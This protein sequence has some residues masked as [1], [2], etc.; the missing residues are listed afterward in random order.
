LEHG[1]DLVIQVYA[2]DG[3]HLG[4]FAHRGAGDAELGFSNGLVVDD[5]GIYAV[6]VSGLPDFGLRSAVR[7]WAPIE[8]GAAPAAP[9]TPPKVAWVTTTG[10]SDFIP[11]SLAKAP[12][13]KI[14]AS[15]ALT[16]EFAIFSPDGTYL[17][18]WGEPGNGD[19][20]FDL[21]RANGDPFGMLAFAPD[22]S[23][24]VLD[25]G[26]HR[27]QVFDE[28]RRFVR[29]WG[30]FGKEPGQ[31]AETGG[32]V[33]DRDGNVVVVDNIRNVIET[34]KPD[35]T[36]VSTVT[37]FPPEANVATGP[38]KGANQMALG[39][40]GD[41]FLGAAE[42]GVVIEVDRTGKLVRTWGA[43]GD[44]CALSEQP[45]GM[46]W[47]AQGRMYLGQGPDRGDAPGILVF[48]SDGSCLGGFGPEGTSD[49]QVA[50]PWGIVVDDTGIYVA[51]AGGVPDMGFRSSITKFEP[52]AP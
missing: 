27:V 6:D 5:T 32:L 19:G 25:S 18:T 41:L 51:D 21:R 50:F 39:P 7:K 48:G 13:G 43:A 29:S 37:A 44:A 4:G 38:N 17:E 3:S 10:P 15:L 52:L 14:W 35:G 30:T 49:G 40:N 28:H 8:F 26:N 12:D 45:N 2:P 11:W 42:P 46:A 36:V 24:Y 34:Y 20:Q 22:G 23:F 47:D 16:D 9:V 33:V 1:A 31:F